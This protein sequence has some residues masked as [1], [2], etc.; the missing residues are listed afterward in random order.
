[1]FS[2]VN[3]STNIVN[4]Y[5]RYL[6]T[7]FQLN[8]EEYTKLFKKELSKV[9]SFY[10]GPYL[11]VSNSYRKESS[12]EELISIGKLNKD[13][14][15]ININKERQLYSHQINALNKVMLGK[16][17]VVSTGTGSGKTE[18]FL[19]PI[20]N[21][22]VSEQ[23]K[24]TLDSGVRALLIYPMNA[25]ANDQIDRL[26]V[27]LKDYPE[28]T[29]GSYTGQTENEE[30]SAQNKYY[31]LNKSKPII[32]ELISRE[33]MH[34]SPPNILITNYSML[35][36]L[37]LRPE[38]S[39]FFSSKFADKWK[40]IVLDEAHVYS[41][42]TGIE[43]SYLLKRLNTR[44]EN[45]NIQYILTSATLGSEEENDD[46]ASFAQDL[47][48]SKFEGTDVIRA[49]RVN[50]QSEGNL[51]TYDAK[52]YSTLASDI[53]TSSEEY[54]LGLLFD[55][56][57]V[58]S[59]NLNNALY[60][61]V[62]KDKNYWTIKY[63]LNEP[64]TIIEISEH[65]NWT[66]KE[67]EDFVYV[68]S[69]AVKNE[70]KLFD[71]RYHMFLKS[72][73]SVF[74]TLSPLK[75]VFL[76][77]KKIH[78]ENSR[79]YK[80]F[81]ISTCIYCSSIYIH[82]EIDIDMKL[83][84]K[85]Q[86]N[87]DTD[88]HVFLLKD[89]YSNDN[90]DNEGSDNLSE[91]LLCPYCG[92]IVSENDRKAKFCEHSK[93]EY[94]KVIKV[95]LKD[96][97]KLTKCYV[98]ENKNNTGVLRGFY[99][100]HE[101]VSS[102]I[103]SA[104][105]EE[106]PSTLVENSKKINSGGFGK[107][108][109]QPTI[110]SLA[111]QFLAFS[112]SRQ[113]A[114]YFASYF[115]TTYKQLLFRRV[116]V[117]IISKM[118][119]SFSISFMNLVDKLELSFLHEL[120]EEYANKLA[121]QTIYNELFNIN[122]SNSLSKKGLIK[123]NYNLETNYP[124]L[125]LTE[126]ELNDFCMII[127]ETMMQSGA[128]N[129]DGM[130]AGLT[131]N[132]YDFFTYSSKLPGFKLN[133]T[134][135][136]N[137]TISFTPSKLNGMNKRLDYV[138][139]LMKKKGIYENDEKALRILEEVFN[140]FEHDL[141]IRDRNNSSFRIN[142][143]MLNVS[144]SKL[145]KCDK[146]YSYTHHNILN[147]CPSYKCQGNLHEVIP[148]E[149]FKDD[150]Y[151]QLYKTM[152][153]NSMK[154]V[155]HTAQLSSEKAYAFQ[156]EFVDKK[157]NILSCSTTF[158][159][160]VDVGTLETV[161]LR[162]MP[163]SPANYS[164]RAGRAGRSKNS[165]AFALTFCNRSSHDFS[166]FNRP[167]EMIKGKIRPP[168]FK[169]DN[170]KI[171]IRHLYA[172]ALSKFW[173]ENPHLFNDAE[174]F[175]EKGGYFAFRNFILSKP[176]ELKN[177]L[178]TLFSDRLIDEFQINSFAWGDF[179]YEKGP[180]KQSKEEYDYIID[181]LTKS[182]DLKSN[183]KSIDYRINT[184]HKEKIISFFSNRNILPKY[185]FPVDTVDLKISLDKSN[186][187]TGVEL[188]RDLSMAI[189]EY[190]PGSQVVANGKI[191]TSRYIS[192]IPSLGWRT[193]AH[194]LCTHCLTLNVDE[195]ST[196]ESLEKILNEC[197]AC[198]E[199]LTE[200]K[201]K[202]IIPTFGFTS[203]LD[204]K[205]AGIKKPEKTYRTDVYYVG[206]QNNIIFQELKI[207][208]SILKIGY[209]EKDKL[210]ML[211]Q[212]NFYVC[213]KCGYSDAFRNIFSNSIT[214]KHKD[215]R[216]KNCENSYLKKYTLGYTFETDVL[217]IEFEQPTIDSREKGLSILFA[218]LEGISNTLNI[219][220]SDINGVLKPGVLDGYGNHKISFVIFDNTPGGSG[221]VKQLNNQK[222]I[223]QVIQRTYDLMINCSCGD[224]EKMET[225]CYACLRNYYN[226]KH[227]HIL[228]R[229]Y[230]VNFLG[231]LLG[232]LDKSEI[233]Q[234]SNNQLIKNQYLKDFLS[235]IELNNYENPIIGYEFN[236]KNYTTAEMVWEESKLAIIIE[237]QTN[238]EDDIQKLGWEVIMLN[239]S[240]ISEVKKLFKEKIHG[241][242]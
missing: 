87:L 6:N 120:N 214:E 71:S 181:L 28:I 110:T 136:V 76:E 38:S 124:I 122:T 102:V 1:M 183:N 182:K 101:A 123:F 217:H 9:G 145:Y 188:Q 24:N 213:E 158:E 127:A 190:A 177:E 206:H 186:Q 69:K 167:K 61:L 119:K 157:I 91:Y 33:K 208:G 174:T 143:K 31:E 112:D 150:H 130:E 98:C 176:S 113:A 65:M 146:C 47:C 219:E 58:S 34:L 228:Q 221:Y 80:V 156:K 229:G 10:K 195:Y 89:K 129:V 37:L 184:I 2:P 140:D 43:V 109:N 51:F 151:Y 41:G 230:V 200:D 96:S 212:S 45:P 131:E 56:Y 50:L 192:I 205:P 199:K 128:I 103:S 29:F 242:K 234:S 240:N 64:K 160:G 227:H 13:F 92:H 55:V 7:I 108:L 99:S 82:G 194:S 209:S 165:A 42:S 73:E 118:D 22:L 72:T 198:K 88:H 46:V 148:D 203:D 74:I 232:V 111:K 36:Y 134:E 137:K 170:E 57:H 153:I 121:Y 70:I 49:E 78:I 106:L 144:V 117:N 231:E 216:G 17:I 236:S 21:S 97:K 126:N 18:S 220:R 224:K 5:L 53:E 35:E 125:N 67:V 8:D 191:I 187:A 14:A 90:E 168:K 132:D 138:I 211:N 239:E 210:A 197:K 178:K 77:R 173:R 237:S 164:Q 235:W 19:I 93:S 26:R 20:L 94:V 40:Y 105:Y 104:L 84:Q 25:L 133:I 116:L 16:N 79:E 15:R 135:P 162:N 4:K 100:G 85:S 83:Q 59:G 180:L 152:E 155:E 241:S 202:A 44:L 185:G 172:T 142:P 159:M 149:E 161:F 201:K 75:R 147:I 223:S 218:L 81:E 95:K 207:E 175:M 60:D 225:S 226:Q 54:V 32:N 107:R 62:I 196:D 86:Y 204:I 30:K 233:Q 3:A 189:S 193:F 154:I 238:Y 66:I 141:L 215:S 11:D 48:S 52:T 27:V 39:V 179:L 63:F 68:A 139:R 114:A 163:P 169:V 171:A 222:I 23:E 115:D 166:Y 12:I